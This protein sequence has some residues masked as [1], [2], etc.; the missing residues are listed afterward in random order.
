MCVF[1]I[2]I[3]NPLIMLEQ[4]TFFFLFFLL[5]LKESSNSMAPRF[6]HRKTKIRSTL[7]STVSLPCA[8]Q[9]NPKAKINWFN[10]TSSSLAGSNNLDLTRSR[11]LQDGTLIINNLALNDQGSYKCLTSNQLGEEATLVQLQI[12]GKF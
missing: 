10:E 6:V 2:H 1:Q 12:T 7:G 11:I 4:N 8:V 5:S 9:A 3:T